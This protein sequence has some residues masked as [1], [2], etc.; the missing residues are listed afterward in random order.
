MLGQQRQ[1][2]HRSAIIAC[3]RASHGISGHGHQRDVAGI[4]ETGRQHGQGGLGA[5]A[6]IHFAR[7]VQ[8]HAEA[9]THEV[10]DRLFELEYP[11]VRVTAVLRL[12]DLLGH[13]SANVLGCHGI[14]LAD[15]E[16]EQLTIGKIGQ[17]LSLGALDL[18]ELVDVG[19]HPVAGSTDPVCKKLL[20]IGGAHD[21]PRTKNPRIRGAADTRCPDR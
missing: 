7:R 19:P 11:V 13:P 20:K 10:S 16:I 12:A 9:A 3:V 8:V 14:I 21:L 4:D 6:V 18:L 1:F 17:D 5:D 2:V 15:P